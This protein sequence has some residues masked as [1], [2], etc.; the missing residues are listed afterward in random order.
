MHLG[1]SC[2]RLQIQILLQVYYKKCFNFKILPNRSSVTILRQYFA[3]V[4]NGTVPNWV[5]GEISLKEFFLH[6]WDCTPLKG[7]MSVDTLSLIENFVVKASEKSLKEVFGVDQELSLEWKVED[8]I[9]LWNCQKENVLISIYAFFVYLIWLHCLLYSMIW[10]SL[11]LCICLFYE[12]FSISSD[13]FRVV[14][15]FCPYSV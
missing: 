11:N 2:L 7:I 14:F 4:S 1:S 12:I 15:N 5:T 13:L 3:Q 8:C 9:D 6:V 10:R